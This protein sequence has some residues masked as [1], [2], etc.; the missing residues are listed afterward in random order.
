M[1]GL[2]GYCTAYK[3]GVACGGVMGTHLPHLVIH[4]VKEPPRGDAAVP[5]ADVVERWKWRRL[6][7]HAR[8]EVGVGCFEPFRVLVHSNIV[9]E[10]LEVR[11]VVPLV[12][13]LVEHVDEVGLAGAQH[14]GPYTGGKNI[15]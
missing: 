9:A 7:H 5:G 15:S 11:L 4:C 3:C 8:R 10:I 14:A 1:H 13:Q 2:T 12:M 6:A